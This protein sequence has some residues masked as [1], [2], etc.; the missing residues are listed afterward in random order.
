VLGALLGAAAG[1][2][3]LMVVP[4]FLPDPA[5]AAYV[6][7]WQPRAILRG[8]ALGTT[9]A[10]VFSLPSLLSVLRVPP[11][12]VF[13]SDAQ[14]LPATRALEGGALALT[15]IAVAAMA[16]FQAG[17][18]DVAWRFTAGVLG[19][20]LALL[21]AAFVVRRAVARIP[22]GALPGRVPLRHGL[23]AIARPASATQGAVMALGLGLLVVLA[24]S[25]VELSLTRQLTRELPDDAP[26]A[27]LIGIQPEQWP[28]LEQTLREAGS[29]RVESV[30]VIVARLAEVDGRTVSEL[31]A[32]A[33][34][35]RRWALTREQRITYVDELPASNQLLAG[36][37]WSRAGVAEIS[38]EEEFADDLGIELGSTIGFDVQGVLLELVVTSI[39]RVD[40]ESFDVNFF[41]IAEP[42][43][44][45]EAPQA[46]L[47][48]VRMPAGTEQAAQ[49]LVAASF[50]NVTVIRVREL[51]ERVL[52]LLR[53]LA[54]GV[55]V[56][57]S[58]TVISALAILAGAVAAGAARRGTEVALLKTLGMTRFDVVVCFATE[59]AL[60][61]AIAGL[62]GGIGGVVVSAVVVTQAIEVEW[63]FEAWRLAATFVAGIL[64]S[65]GA[66][67]LASSRALRRR[68]IE[69]LRER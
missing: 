13:R 20:A 54:L 18:W 14:P 55:R 29:E 19:T 56:L 21:L 28:E 64:L 6:D 50:P 22:R 33:D 49:D 37:L 36:E 43:A 40:W 24:M 62:I 31:A 27:F 25:L 38:V 2:C 3:A 67:V 65:A 34:R 51:L 46:R 63:S 30:P 53:K 17:D 68:P 44:V 26:S 5:L 59:Y 9:V 7:P 15:V 41:L 12:R 60:Q 1:I 58:F 23:A 69:V 52:A 10:V 35:S 48:A 66:G 42:E 16:A 8:A 11:S 4:H 32:G 57:G 39:R 61:G 47:A 45:A